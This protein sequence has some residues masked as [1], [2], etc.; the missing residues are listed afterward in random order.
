MLEFPSSGQNMI[1]LKG[2]SG[3]PSS[4]EN[5]KYLLD[6]TSSG[7]GMKYPLEW[8]NI[9]DIIKMT[10]RVPLQWTK[11]AHH[12]FWH[13]PSHAAGALFGFF[14]SPAPQTPLHK[15][16]HRPCCEQ[17]HKINF[18]SSRKEVLLI[19]STRKRKK[20][21]HFYLKNTEKHE[22]GVAL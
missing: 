4:R 13:A 5:M 10:S 18:L 2:L 22:G 19:D 16:I 9:Q 14:L 8:R 7:E 1:K 11:H 6:F 3:C 21:G 15:I 20:V 12:D 17:F